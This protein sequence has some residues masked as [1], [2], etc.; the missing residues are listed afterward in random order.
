MFHFRS[1]MVVPCVPYKK[2]GSHVV[3]ME[4][5]KGT[6]TE[7]LPFKRAWY[8]YCLNA[9]VLVRTPAKETP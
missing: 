3:Q 1:T 9:T 2:Y 6:R 4:S 7:S 8:I 5:E